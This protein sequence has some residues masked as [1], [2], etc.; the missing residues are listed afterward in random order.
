MQPTLGPLSSIAP[1]RVI[2]RLGASVTSRLSAVASILLLCS[3]IADAQ[4]PL[5]WAR[6]SGG[7]GRTGG[8]TE[9]YRGSFAKD[10]RASVAL[11]VRASWGLEASAVM[12]RPTSF[13]FD[14]NNVFGCAASTCSSIISYNA[15]G[16]AA[17]RGWTHK[18]EQV[19]AIS[20]GVLAVRIFDNAAAGHSTAIGFQ[21]GTD[22]DIHRSARIALSVGTRVVLIPSV[23]GERLWH[24]PLELSF[25]TR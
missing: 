5:A 18:T 16:L 12:Q 15:L 17:V 25:R 20:G 23:N 2:A 14:G 8:G 1:F 11:R 7:I 4:V 21:V 22:R 3:S 19:G 13:D 9:V 24:V 6:V 10:L